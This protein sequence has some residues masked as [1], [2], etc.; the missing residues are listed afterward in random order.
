MRPLRHRDPG[1][2]GYVLATHLTA[3]FIGDG[4]HLSFETVRLLE[5]IKAPDE[6]VLVTDALAGLGMPPGQYRI[7]GLDY[8]SDGSRGQLSDGT[9]SGSLL[10]LNRAVRNLVIEVGVDPAVAV[11]LATLNPARLLGLEDTL[12]RV[13]VGRS[14]DLVLIDAAWEVAEAFVGGVPAVR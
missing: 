1:L 3:G 5:R 6:L 8:F 11:G 10:P 4:N 12:G 14:A 13:E 9:L 7:G 2:V